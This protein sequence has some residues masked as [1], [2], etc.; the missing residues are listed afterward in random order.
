MAPIAL[1][2]SMAVRPEPPPAPCTSSTSPG[3]ISAFHLS[4]PYAVG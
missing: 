4:A 2:T 1:P 3:R